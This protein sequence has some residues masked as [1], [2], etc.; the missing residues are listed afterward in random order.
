VSEEIEQRK[1]DHLRLAAAMP[2]AVRGPGFED[3]EFVHEALPE[4][5]FAAVDPSVELLGRRFG[6]PL[7]I[8]GMTGGH[9]AGGDVN[10]CLARAAQ[11]HRLPMGL[12]SQR[13]ALRDPRLRDTYEV[14]RREGPDA[15]LIANVGAPQL[16]PQGDSPPLSST[17]VAELIDMIRA[18]AIAV[19]LNATQE[20][21]QPEGD[22]NAAGW[23]DAIRL[24]VESVSI[25]VIAKETGGGI[26]EAT[27]RRLAGAGV[28]AI[29]VGGRG[30][31]SFAAIEGRR[32]AE[33]DDERG[34]RLAEV[35]A[36]WGVPTAASIALS[37]RAGLPVIATGG[38]RSGLDAARAIVLGASAVGVARPFL[39][40]VLD[41]GDDEV[42]RF[43]FTFRAELT[44]VQFLRGSATIESLR[45]A[46]HLVRGETSAWLAAA[47]E[48]RASSPTER[49]SS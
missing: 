14:A 5:D 31:T 39:Q 7:V 2:A 4:I 11:R 32:A 37:S 1:A 28:A 36:A 21:V 3:V 44:G 16:V 42:D 26:S 19:H 34:V 41:G 15:F 38:V 29:D 45:S 27:A 30:G 35:F 13:A 47:G 24:L 23:L 46:P 9:A 48:G 17:Q 18:D 12:G 22:R 10:A 40:A 43:V 20:L 49:R 8:A 6:L 25:P 33:Q